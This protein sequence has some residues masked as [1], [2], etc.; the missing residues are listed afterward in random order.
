MAK[1]IPQKLHL[2]CGKKYMA[3]WLNV[4]NFA[5]GVDLKIDL[6][7]IPWKIPSNHFTEVLCSHTLEH[8]E[9]TQGF[10]DEVWRVCRGGAKIKIIVPHFSSVAAASPFHKKTFNSQS[11]NYFASGY[12]ERYG[13]SNFCVESVRLRWYPTD[14]DYVNFSAKRKI[15]FAASGLIDFAINLNRNFFERVWW[16]YV[17]GAFEIEWNLSPV[18]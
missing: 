4:D 10:M 15:V 5:I 9:D 16:P 2:G 1:K 13:K 14:P 7:K 3:G 8:L 12:H 6:D 17:G 11:M 18:K